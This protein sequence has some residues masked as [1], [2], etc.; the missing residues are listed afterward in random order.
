MICAHN[1][2]L[3]VLRQ[4]D[5]REVHGL[6]CR[7]ISRLRVAK[8]DLLNIFAMHSASSLA[9]LAHARAAAVYIRYN[10]VMRPD[11]EYLKLLLAAF[12]GAQAPTTNVRELESAGFSLDDPKFEFHMM[13]LQDSGFM[14]GESKAGGIGLSKASDGAIQWSVLP[15]RL[16]ASGHEF[17]EAMG[18]SKVLQTL[19]KSFVGASI[20]TMRDLA[21]AIVKAE[22]AKHAGLH[23]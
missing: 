19:K 6:I 21:V 5:N 13:L 17:A 22:I 2:C 11:A 20:S 8:C 12:Q 4:T 15:L 10:S 3:E 23:A 18:N 16:T 14:E 1:S 7:D 9:I